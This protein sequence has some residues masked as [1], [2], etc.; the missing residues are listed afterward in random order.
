M[1]TLMRIWDI[2]LSLATIQQRRRR[3]NDNSPQTDIVW[4][5]KN[6]A[7]VIGQTER[8]TYHL[9]N[10]GLLPAKKIGDR[11]VSTRTKLIEHITPN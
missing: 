1:L 4:E 3:L 11:W 6:I 9:L 7:A 2:F 10:A 8:Q 5:V